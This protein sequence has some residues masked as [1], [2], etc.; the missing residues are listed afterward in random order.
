MKRF[1]QIGLIFFFI[2]VTFSCNSLIK[3][4][5]AS[6]YDIA[7]DKF[8][9]DLYKLFLKYRLNSASDGD[10]II[11]NIQHLDKLVAFYTQ[12][13]YTPVWTRNML[14][15]AIIDT[16][17]SY[18]QNS[19]IHGLHP[20]YYHTKLIRAC[21]AEYISSLKTDTSINYVSLANLEL[22]ISNALINYRNHLTCGYINPKEVDPTS[23]HLPLNQ[24]DSTT[25]FAPLETKNIVDYLESIQPKNEAYIY[26]QATLERYRS[27]KNKGG[28]STINIIFKD[29]DKVE[30]GDTAY[31]LAELA[32][33]LII[34]GELEASYTANPIDLD[35]ASLYERVSHDFSDTTHMKDIQYYIYDNQLVNAVERFQMSHG[36]FV[37]GI[38]GNQTLYHLNIPVEKKIAQIKINL[39]R[40]RWFSY[41]ENTEYILVNIPDYKLYIIN[42]GKQKLEMNVCVG[43]SRDKNYN[44]KLKLFRKKRDYNYYPNNKE[45]PLLHGYI[46]HFV[47][48]PKWYV[49]ENIGRNEIFYKALKDPEYLSKH[50]FKVYQDGI[51]I[52]ADSITWS[53]YEPDQFPFRFQQDAYAGNALGKVKFIFENNYNIYLHDSPNK[54]AFGYTKRDVSH[55]CIRL[56]KPIEL[57]EY[58]AK[59]IENM[60]A[61][62]IRICLGM[63]PKNTN[64]NTNKN[65]SKCESQSVCLTNQIPL[66]I[67]YFTSWVDTKGIVHFRDDVY[68]K[69][70]LLLSY[71]I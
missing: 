65:I 66:Y 25:Y 48:N 41:P 1:I 12:N 42:N 20:G 68:L 29:N 4:T 22:L 17:T 34:S 10:S 39:E 45:T 43:K 27:I 46:S 2:A 31:F 28:W 52:S 8:D 58:L 38:I 32:K 56:E 61:D 62:E 51:E 47:L 37:D 15:H 57:A 71:M 19:E 3:K 36:L 59:D 54:R 30:P 24:P 26:L 53:E 9:H 69:D 63:Q 13:N 6:L 33:R 7:N 11:Q 35:S 5:E 70:K 55:G 40:L 49:P 64:Q 14:N 50:N 18:F 44:E 21:L 23:Y 16:I 67:N 60:S